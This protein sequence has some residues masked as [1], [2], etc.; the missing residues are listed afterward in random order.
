M[1]KVD[2]TWPEERAK[3]AAADGW[4]L[5]YTVDSGKKT[6]G[7]M[8]FPV[9]PRLPDPTRAMRHVIAQAQVGTRLHMAAIR[10]MQASR[11]MK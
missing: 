11:S 1:S 8:V 6:G 7:Y 3:E 10:A 4:L 9:G 5:A 2:L